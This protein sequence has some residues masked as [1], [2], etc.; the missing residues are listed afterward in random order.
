[1]LGK[2]FEDQPYLVHDAGFRS[3]QKRIGIE[4]RA[5]HHWPNKSWH[6]FRQL[7]DRLTAEGYD[8]FYFVR[9]NSLREYLDEIRGC[10]LVVCGDSLAMHMALAYRI[11]AVTIFNCTSPAEIYDYG[12][13]EKIVSPLI[14]DY[15]YDRRY[16]PE[17]IS[18]VSVDS[19]YEAVKRKLRSE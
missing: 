14:H 15:Y 1:M 4:W 11:P 7:G 6:G 2:Q 5:G 8:V 12:L 18:S 16:S 19:V 10:S 3:R 17:V 9:R 13:L